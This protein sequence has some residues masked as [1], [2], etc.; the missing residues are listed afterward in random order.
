MCEKKLEEKELSDEI[1]ME[2]PWTCQ[3]KR[4][5]KTTVQRTVGED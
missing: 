4:E 1:L 5:I 2:H 3:G